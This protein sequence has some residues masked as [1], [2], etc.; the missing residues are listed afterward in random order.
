M[1]VVIAHSTQVLDKIKGY[2][3]TGSGTSFDTMGQFVDKIETLLV[4]EGLLETRE[5]DMSS[6]LTY[7]E[8]RRGYPHP[9]SLV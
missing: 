2:A 8:V 1:K 9:P 6:Q 5:W 4:K 3:G 7:F